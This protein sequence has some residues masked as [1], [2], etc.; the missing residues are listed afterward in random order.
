MLAL[1][2]R[3]EVNEVNRIN[4]STTP[5]SGCKF[6]KSPTKNATQPKKNKIH[7]PHSKKNAPNLALSER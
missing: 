2:W 4:S 1:S 7:I 3:G 6:S 5:F